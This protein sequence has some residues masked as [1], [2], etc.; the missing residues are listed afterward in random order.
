MT[1]QDK[2]K[3]YSVECFN[4]V[5]ELLDKG[6]RSDTEN[7]LMREMA[8][9]SLYHWLMREDVSA[10]NIS[11]GLWQISRVHAVLGDGLA[12]GKYALEC[13]EISEKNL[14][15]PFYRGYAYEAL[16]RSAIVSGDLKAAEENLKIAHAMAN[17]I[18]ESDD[19]SSL[20]KELT[21]L[22]E[23]LHA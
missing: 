15:S 11:I 7:K 4:G 2:H 13:R 17:D 18:T 14:L 12:A 8:H 3:R 22:K 10:K 19:Q 1:E 21:E 20:V 6:N 23:A 5:W 9:A 16:A